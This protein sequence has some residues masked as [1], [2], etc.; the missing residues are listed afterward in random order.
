ME[1]IPIES[2]AAG[3]RTAA[4]IEFNDLDDSFMI[5]LVAGTEDFSASPD[6]VQRIA[7]DL[8]NA[9]LSHHLEQGFNHESFAKNG[10]KDFVDRMVGYIENGA[11]YAR[12]Q[13]GS[14]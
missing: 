7:R 9:R 10:S 5:S 11:E 2:Y 3:Q 1:E 6:H 14:Q 13:E 4:P 8:S 12:Q